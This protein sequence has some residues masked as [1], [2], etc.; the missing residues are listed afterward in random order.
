MTFVRGDYDAA[1]RGLTKLE[2]LGVNVQLSTFNVQQ[3]REE[4]TCGVLCV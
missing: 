1:E 3:G 2:Q 4:G